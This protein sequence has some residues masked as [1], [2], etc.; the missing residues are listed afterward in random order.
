MQQLSTKT[1]KCIFL[2]LCFLQL[3]CQEIFGQISIQK[4]H[5]ELEFRIL[6]SLNMH[7]I[8][9]MQFLIKEFNPIGDSLRKTG[10]TNEAGFAQISITNSSKIYFESILYSKHS[11]LTNDLKTGIVNNILLIPLKNELKEIVVNDRPLYG[12]NKIEFRVK[13]IHKSQAPI[14]QNFLKTINGISLQSSDDKY[15]GKIIVFYLDGIKI[16]SKI[17]KESAIESFEKLE[18]ISASDGEYWMK[19]SEVIFNFISKK[20][21]TP[22]LGI[23]TNTELAILFPYSSQNLGIY[24]L[25][26]RS[27]FRVSTLLYSYGQNVQNNLNQEIN[28]IKSHSKQLLETTTTPNFNTFI[29]NYNLDS[30]TTISF[31]FGYQNIHN[32]QNSNFTFSPLISESLDQLQSES[33]RLYNKSKISNLI[34]L[35]RQNH[36]LFI[37]Y[38]YGNSNIK[39][40]YLDPNELNQATYEKSNST[41]INYANRLQLSKLTKLNT[42]L[43]W[44]NKNSNTQYNFQNDNSVASYFNSNFIGLRSIFATS[45]KNISILIG[46]RLDLI[47]QEFE[48]NSAKY[49]HKNKVRFLPT[50]SLQYESEKIGNF[51]FS[52]NSDYIL[53]DISQLAS[54][55]RRI[56]PFKSIMGNNMLDTENNIDLSL[57]HMININQLE[58]S[59]ELGYQESDNQ[60]GYSPYRIEKNQLIYSYTNLGKSKNM[61]FQISSSLAL[62]KSITCQVNLAQKFAQFYLNPIWDYSNFNSNWLPIFSISNS[63]DYQISSR[64]SA[65]LNMYFDNYSYEFFETKQYFLPN[66]GLTFNG[67]MGRDWNFSMV[68]NTIFANANLEKTHTSQQ[69]YISNSS[70]ITNYRYVSISI[71]KSFGKKQ[72]NVP[73][74]S[75]A[76]EVKRKFKTI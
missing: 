34:L 43:S 51:N 19:P 37:R 25:G 65:S 21:K 72:N 10:I 55:S 12:V 66:A 49:R 24:Y 7:P 56:D 22:T 71:Q 4:K 57:T 11:V 54:F 73:E 68:W 42:T 69:N 6:D 53:P 5:Q 52:I 50:L 41:Y 40:Q 33:N 75:T 60:L 70:I 59:T 36:K 18:I 16:E 74:S 44:E 2:T 45:L 13:K 63:W 28:Q 1:I 61:S 20:P 23:Q 58:L 31:H 15:L 9:F 62:S 30:L 38:D 29:F 76:D 14:I 27:S 35:K 48:S 17:I 64:F 67:S 32:S 46:G 3:T 47:N 8:P 39:N 26:K